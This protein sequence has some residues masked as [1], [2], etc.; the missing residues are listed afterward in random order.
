MAR[1]KEMVANA[2][3]DV[4]YNEEGR[5]LLEAVNLGSQSAPARY[6]PCDALWRHPQ[7]GAV[8]YVGGQRMADSREELRKY[9]ITR[10]VNCQEETARNSFEGDRELEYLRFCIGLWRNVPG[11]R[12]DDEILW[13]FY[14]PFFTFVTQNLL[15]GRSVLVHC[16]AGA[17]RAGTAGISCL[18]MF[19]GW[20][21]KQAAVAAKKLRPAI[22]PIGGFTELLAL[23][24]KARTGREQSIRLYDPA[25]RSAATVTAPALDEGAA[26]GE[27][28]QDCQ[29][30]GAVR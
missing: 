5:K 27:G 18:M 12:Q 2:M 14:E 20:A 24:E 15:E 11:I 8:L 23:L 13:R 22:E 1:C 4:D 19:C 16:L 17:H 7:T 28:R 29:G 9:N 30:D 10:I 21:P 3:T 6:S 26:D 25:D